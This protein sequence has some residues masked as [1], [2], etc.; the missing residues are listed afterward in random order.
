M[1][2]LSLTD[3]NASD[4]DY[5]QKLNNNNTAIEAAINTLQAQVLASVGEGVDLIL[6]TYDRDGIV[7]ST[8]YVL[9]LD[10]Y[11][12]GSQITIGRRPG[13]SFVGEIDKSIAWGTYSGERFRVS[14]SG[15]LV[16]DA[17]SIVSGLPKTIYVGI[18]SSGVPQLFESGIVINVLYAY[19][20]TWD[21]YSLKD[22]KR[23]APILPAYSTIQAIAGAPHFFPLFDTETDW[24]SEIVGSCEITLPGAQDDNEI[25]V[26]GSVEVLG[27][28]MTAGKA[29]PDGFAASGVTPEDNLVS[30]K[31]V[32]ELED[33]TETP[34]EFD[35]SNVPD[36][37]FKKIN[38][39]LGVK[40]FITEV[41][42][43]TLE[44]VALGSFVT[45]ARA[46]TWGIIYRPL[47]GIAIPK[48]QTKV[49]LI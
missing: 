16:L 1:P 10:N 44:R 14:M 47:I 8:S 45:S 4:L 40:K 19:S 35:A 21:G 43:F 5:V 30:V 25:L 46:F 49:V 15:D 48:D 33:W 7:G 41:Q 36:T 3:F 32:S 20:M 11:P 12:G 6:D 24:L 17:I 39:A 42:R 31:V 34:F 13:P 37:I 9:D 2:P 22:F 26:D 18:P 38:P 23:L 29:G 28:F 27:F